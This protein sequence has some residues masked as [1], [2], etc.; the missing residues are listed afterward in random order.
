MVKSHMANFFWDDLEGKHKYY[1]SNW[2]S[3]AQRKEHG[4]LGVPDLRDLNL[5]LP[6]S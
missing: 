4:G 3:I 2:G 6:A 5:C 1:L